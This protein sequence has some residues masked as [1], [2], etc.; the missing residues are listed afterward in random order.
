MKLL[1]N[2][3]IDNLFDLNEYLIFLEV[4]SENN[5]EIKNI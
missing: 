3:L 4:N 2:L 5:L 1:N